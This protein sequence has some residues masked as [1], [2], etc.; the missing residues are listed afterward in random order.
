MSLNEAAQ[1]QCMTYCEIPWNFNE[2]NWRNRIL[3]GPHSPDEL[4]D[5]KWICFKCAAN[6]FTR[7][8]TILI[9]AYHMKP[10]SASYPC[11]ILIPAKS[12]LGELYWLD[13]FNDGIRLGECMLSWLLA[14]L[15]DRCADFLY[16]LDLQWE[17]KKKYVYG[18]SYYIHA[19]WVWLAYSHAQ[20]RRG[21]QRKPPLTNKMSLLMN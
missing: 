14:R 2:G 18:L 7:Q 5:W 10:A 16:Y 8:G 20:G 1:C 11:L 15:S 3:F 6:S 17:A 4:T 13:I 19:H 9:Y 12:V 21:L